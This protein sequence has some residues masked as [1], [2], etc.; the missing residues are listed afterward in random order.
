[1]VRVIGTVFDVD[2]KTNSVSVNVTKGVV[3]VVAGD[4]QLF[5][6]AGERFETKLDTLQNQP[7]KALA[8]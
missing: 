3:S 5:L 4:K 1:M 6:G 7:L 8:D 2:V